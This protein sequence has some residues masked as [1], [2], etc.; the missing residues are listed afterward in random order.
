MNSNPFV[1]AATSSQPVLIIRRRAESLK[2]LT[3]LSKSLDHCSNSYSN[4]ENA[5]LTRRDHDVVATRAQ[6]RQRLTELAVRRAV[7]ARRR[8]VLRSVL[9]QAVRIAALGIP[10][11]LWVATFAL[12]P[13][14]GT[15]GVQPPGA[16]G[17]IGIA[18]TV[19]IACVL[20]GF[21]PARRA[22]RL[23]PAEAL[24]RAA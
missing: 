5:D 23:P 6:V 24:R 20:G 8:T 7:G 21:G 1:H 4:T 9:G 12:Q 19:L 13:L 11:G 16:A 3:K 10:L 2:H 14:R 22:S 18:V 15:S 17:V